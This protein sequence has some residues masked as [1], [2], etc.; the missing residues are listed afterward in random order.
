MSARTTRGA[1]AALLA[2]MAVIAGCVSLRNGDSAQAPQRDA[3]T[4]FVLV[5]HAEKATDD[6]KDPSLSDAG[7]ARA[8]RLASS[9]DGVAV[10]AVYATG[11]RRTQATAQP[12]AEAH[13]LPVR[14]YEAGLT[15]DA[16]AARLRATHAS[17]TVLVVGHSNTVPAIASALCNCT[18]TPMREDEFDRRIEVR[19]AADG[20]ATL[21][22]TRY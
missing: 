21:A 10:T 13:G 17:G 3:T 1:C 2:G 6:P 18:V 14:T 7:R 19:I 11:Y 20:A 22:E 4:T 9:F 16:F 5:R 12:T 8:V 15:A